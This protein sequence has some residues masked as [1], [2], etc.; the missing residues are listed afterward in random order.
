MKKSLRKAA[1]SI[2][3]RNALKSQIQ[4]HWLNYVSLRHTNAR[5]QEYG[6]FLKYCEVYEAI[7]GSFDLHDFCE[8]I[9]LCAPDIDYK[10]R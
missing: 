3:T 7:F 8:K 9:E 4:F 6:R 1:L 10:K 2:E 5:M